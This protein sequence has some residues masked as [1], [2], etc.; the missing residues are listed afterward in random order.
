[1]VLAGALLPVSG[2]AAEPANADEGALMQIEALND[3]WPDRWLGRHHYLFDD[4]YTA[5]EYA[6]EM[7][8]VGASGA[9]ACGVRPVRVLRTDGRTAIVK[10]NPCD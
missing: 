1:M 10:L 4:E 9:R 7:R 6:A 3:R 5:A 2:N 8:T